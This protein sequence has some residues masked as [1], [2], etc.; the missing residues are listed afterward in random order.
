MR[1]L[2][3]SALI[4][5]VVL[6]TFTGNVMAE[7]PFKRLEVK[8]TQ[9]GFAG[10]AG[11]LWVIEPSGKWSRQEVAVGQAQ[12]AEYQNTGMLTQEQLHQLGQILLQNDIRNFEDK[13]GADGRAN[14]RR[15]TI[16]WD[17]K[18]VEVV[19]PAAV[20][21]TALSTTNSDNPRPEDRVAA[22]ARAVQEM[23]Q[24]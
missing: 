21:P 3:P 16:Q 5:C 12:P 9:S 20:D 2:L 22:I 17:D 15:L 4:F 24:K 6:V 8:L 14:P 23:T 7:T 13:L 11:S 1:Q 18:R 19:T 10:E